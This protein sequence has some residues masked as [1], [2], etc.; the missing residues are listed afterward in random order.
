MLFILISL[1]AA[2]ISND[3]IVLDDCISD[4]A[5]SSR[6]ESVFNY[7]EL[8][9]PSPLFGFFYFFQDK[10]YITDSISK[11]YFKIGFCF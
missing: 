4:V 5:F 8:E 7:S 9:L 1:Y 10:L 11:R 2:P 3:L 6:A